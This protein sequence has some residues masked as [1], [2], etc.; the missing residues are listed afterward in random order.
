MLI[1][2]RGPGVGLLE[3]QVVAPGNCVLDGDTMRLVEGELG[4]WKAQES[5]G[6]GDMRGY[7]LCGLARK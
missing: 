5:Y 4:S 2:W 6:L 7:A 1:C 3:H